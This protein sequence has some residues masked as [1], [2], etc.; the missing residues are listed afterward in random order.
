MTI[1]LRSDTLTK[2]T[3][4]MLEA[5]FT[6]EVG[7]DVFEEDPT[8]YKLEHK[9]ATLFGKEA[10]LFCPSGT[11]TNQIGIRINTEPQ[12]EVICHKNSHVYLYEGGG[13]MSNSHVSVKLLEGEYGLLNAA[14]IAEN[15]NDDN[16]CAAKTSLV[17]LENTMNKGGGSCY[18]LE[19]FAAIK[20]V[21]EE[22]NLKMHLDGARI[23]NAIIAKGYTANEVGKYFDT[24]SVCLSKGLGAPVG[25]V[26][27]GTATAIKKARRVRK[28]MG[29]GMRQA[30]Y[31]AAAGIYALDNH[32]ERL[33][34][35]HQRAQHIGKVLQNCTTVKSVMPVETNIVMFE[36]NAPAV[37][38]LE[39]M[40]ALGILAADFGKQ[41]IRLV[42]HY[43]IT[44]DMMNK[45]ETILRKEY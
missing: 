32:V 34:I 16:V 8:I 25:S 14:T 7:D 13:M 42:F 6:A 17:C 3:K 19:T 33:A 37:I 27:L 18:D 31:L 38:V 24:I 22:N 5:M 43:D 11:M 15:I 1:D 12:D 29:G 2:P 20:K 23:F 10:G 28:A 21:C 45:L 41:A 39:K 9:L 44:N 40:K 4:A 35:D 26:L 30:G 36:T